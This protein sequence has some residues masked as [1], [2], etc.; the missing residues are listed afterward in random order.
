MIIPMLLISHPFPGVDNL[1]GVGTVGLET[2][3]F[4][5]QMLSAVKV[6]ELPWPEKDFCSPARVEW[7]IKIVSLGS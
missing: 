1:C 5:L 2:R 6:I 7:N 4:S 3:D